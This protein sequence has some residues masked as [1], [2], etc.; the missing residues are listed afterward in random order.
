[1]V[2]LQEMVTGE[3]ILAIGDGRVDVGLVRPLNLGR[4]LEYMLI[5][6]EPYMV[7]L[8]R[9]HRL[10]CRSEIALKAL[11]GE[12]LITTPAGK[13]RYI[14]S[15]FRARLDTAGISFKIAQEVNQLH[16]MIGLV[17]AA[18]GVALVPTSVARLRLD[19]VVYRPLAVAD[20]PNA[21]LAIAWRTGNN[22]RTLERFVAVANRFAASK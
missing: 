14:D 8:P 18:L 15:R 10:A 21:E 3:Q 7:A 17:G 16:A 2:A 9:R 4:A 20:A 1:M 22:S 19:G 13:R 11:D 6:N 12:R 5:H